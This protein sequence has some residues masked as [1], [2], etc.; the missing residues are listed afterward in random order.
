MSKKIEHA[1]EVSRMRR[2]LAA[3]FPNPDM[4]RQ[5]RIQSALSQDE[6]ASAIGV[7][8]QAVSLY[9]AGDRVPSDET[10]RRYIQLLDGLSERKDA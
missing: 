3:A 2:E 5:V 1:I 9:E 6:V 7:S 8:R 4:L 10:C